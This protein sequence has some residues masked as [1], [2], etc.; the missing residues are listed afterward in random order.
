MGQRPNQ[1]VQAGDTAKASQDPEVQLKWCNKCAALHP[2]EQFWANRSSRDGYHWICKDASREYRQNRR[3]A[4]LRYS[5][6]YHAAHAEEISI[7]RA[8]ER[9]AAAKLYSKA[10]RP[11]RTKHNPLGLPLADRVA[12][13]KQETP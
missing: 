11:Y 8:L 2:L 6:E 4:E 9:Q 12:A 7:R 1:A 10:S 3:A 5:R 13:L